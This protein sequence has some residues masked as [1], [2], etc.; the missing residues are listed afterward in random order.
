MNFYVDII[1]FYANKKYLKL[2][3]KET[4]ILTQLILNFV[5]IRQKHIIPPDSNSY[6]KVISSSV[7]ESSNSRVVATFPTS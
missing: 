6:L 3:K 7:V 1:K 5:P 4:H 2:S